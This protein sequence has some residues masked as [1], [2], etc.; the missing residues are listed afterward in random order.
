MTVG[1]R[2]PASRRLARLRPT[3]VGQAIVVA[4]LLLRA[5]VLLR[6]RPVDSVATTY[7]MLFEE[8]GP[9]QDGPVALTDAERRW[10]HS[11]N[12]LMLRWPLDGSCLRRSLVLGWILRRRH[13]ELV[14]GTRLDDG[15]IRAHAW[16]RLGAID[17]DPDAAHHLRF[18]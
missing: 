1:D 18:T 8:E 17:L 6:I 10:L 14:I 15:E 4:L 13:P 16:V 3:D 11:G 12:R 9:A 2:P 5:E 7:G